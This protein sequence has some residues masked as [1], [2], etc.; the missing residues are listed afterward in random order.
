MDIITRQEALERGLSRFFTGELC[1]HGHID[2]RQTSNGGCLSCKRIHGEAD[3]EKHK[4][5]RRPYWRKHYRQNAEK[6][7]TPARTWHHNNKEYANARSRKYREEHLEEL[8]AKQRAYARANRE[9][10]YERVA[11]FKRLNPGKFN[12]YRQK[13]ADK[14]PGSRP[15]R[16]RRRQA[17]KL[18]GTPKW[19]TKEQCAAMRAIYAEA[20]RLTRET[21]IENHVDHIEPIQGKDRCGLHVPW[22]LQVLTASENISKGN[23]PVQHFHWKKL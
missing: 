23:R 10:S 7:K 17:R 1:L 20:K 2:E 11:K 14:N 8:N 13:W 12:E 15:E 16:V 4:E 18:G 6:I 22:N 21:G 5:E 3:R 9:A 19:L